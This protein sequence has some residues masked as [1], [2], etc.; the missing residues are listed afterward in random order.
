MHKRSEVML[1]ESHV[2]TDFACGR[3]KATTNTNPIP[4]SRNH[5]LRLRESARENVID[6]GPGAR[7][8]S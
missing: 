3:V 8:Q 4:N 7:A 1:I 6:V 5:T 2:R